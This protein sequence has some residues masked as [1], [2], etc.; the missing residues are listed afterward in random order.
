MYFGKAFK[1]E[2]MYK[3]VI[4][5]APLASINEINFGSTYLN[6]LWHHRLGHVHYKRI[7]KMSNL[8]L[9]QTVG[10]IHTRSVRFVHKRILLESLLREFLG[11]QKF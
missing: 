10:V 11:V 8:G 9:F 7:R 5:N 2:R 1:T 3:L 4:V 6:E